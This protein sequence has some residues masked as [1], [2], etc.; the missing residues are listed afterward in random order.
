MGGLVKITGI[1][2]AVSSGEEAI[3]WPLR[4]S[5]QSRRY[6]PAASLR[7]MVQHALS[8]CVAR[9]PIVLA[10]CNGKVTTWSDEDWQTTFDFADIVDEEAARAAAT[11]AELIASG[12]L[13]SRPE[14]EARP[15][16]KVFGRAVA[17][18]QCAS[19]MHA[20][21]L[22]RSLLAAGHPEVTVLAVD[23][24]S[25]PSHDNFESLRVLTDTPAPYTERSTGFQLGE[26]AVALRV[27]NSAFDGVS[28]V[29]PVLGHD[30]EGE[31][32]VDR[33]LGA[34]IQGAEVTEADSLLE[35][36]VGQGAGPAHADHLELT[37]IGKHVPL[38]VPI[39]SA[40][41]NAGHTLGASSLLSVA[42][43][44]A[45][46]PT[47][48]DP[49]VRDLARRL[50][51]APQFVPQ[52]R[53]SPVDI[54]GRGLGASQAL[55]LRA[56]ERAAMDGRAIG[57]P[58]ARHEF[59]LLRWRS[60]AVVRALGGACG[61]VLAGAVERG[62]PT[63]LERRRAEAAGEPTVVIPRTIA[64]SSRAWGPRSEPPPLSVRSR[65][66]LTRIAP[67]IRPICSLSRSIARCHP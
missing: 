22:A 30:L 4:E 55:D 20:L 58:V 1:G 59:R 45:S 34:V 48:V 17:S 26:A 63:I 13:M 64:V 23:I 18:V 6:R 43:A 9:G 38:D 61:A 7:E 53:E 57:M 32:A 3:P 46:L 44:A 62:T 16:A 65:P 37:A 67:N 56:N 28:L 49:Y 33:C 42:I 39:A 66:R 19:G 5:V 24:A 10:S 12:K 36:V 54:D 11:R 50:S 41:A 8:E 27:A 35:L 51:D 21:Y 47:R 2:L 52:A 14:I 40:L 25:A 29:G 60:A 15:A 31:D